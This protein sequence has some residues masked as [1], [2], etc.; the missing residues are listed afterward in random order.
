MSMM[1]GLVLFQGEQGTEGGPGSAGPVG[2]PG[3]RGPAGPEGEI[4]EPVSYHKISFCLFSFYT[5]FMH[6]FYTII[7]V[8]IEII[9]ILC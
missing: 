6:F 1:N 3:E 5:N 7:E 2:A 4:G 9:L 8:W